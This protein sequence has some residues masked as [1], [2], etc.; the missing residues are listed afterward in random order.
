MS[1]GIGL[2]GRLCG[3]K[4]DP[5]TQAWTPVTPAGAKPAAVG[6]NPRT[7][8][9]EPSGRFVYVAG[10]LTGPSRALPLIR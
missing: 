7:V 3:F 5:V 8:V 9:I 4:I 1:G 10:D 2:P 6:S